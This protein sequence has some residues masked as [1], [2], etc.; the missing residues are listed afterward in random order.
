[1]NYKSTK[2][3]E[4]QSSK[5]IYVLALVFWSFGL[6]YM[7]H[8]RSFFKEVI[9][10]FCIVGYFYMGKG[11]LETYKLNTSQNINNEK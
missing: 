6:W 5:I 7:L 1:M 3:Q 9:D 2:L 4:W 10:L 11:I 8:H